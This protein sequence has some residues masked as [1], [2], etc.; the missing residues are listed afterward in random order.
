MGTRCP[1]CGYENRAQAKFCN[2]QTNAEI[3]LKT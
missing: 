1:N 2:Y 3:R